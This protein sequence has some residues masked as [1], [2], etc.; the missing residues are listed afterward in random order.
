M[1]LFAATWVLE[2]PTGKGKEGHEARKAQRVKYQG[3]R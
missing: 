1:A 2:L 3:K